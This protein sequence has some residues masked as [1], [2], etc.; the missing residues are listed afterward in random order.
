[1]TAPCVDQ[2]RAKAECCRD[3]VIKRKWFRTTN[4]V[5]YQHYSA[6]LKPNRAC[7]QAMRFDVVRVPVDKASTEDLTIGG[8]PAASAT[9]HGDQWQ[10][11]VYALR[12]GSDV[13][14]FIFA[15]KQK[16]TESDRNARDTVHSFRRLTRQEIQAARPL[17]ITVITVQPGAT[18]ESL[19]QR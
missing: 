3:N 9:A 6:T 14:R 1:M 5:V 11:K 18:V 4:S 10:F 8:F 12:F 17:R 16:N 15:A 19:S 2:S 7:T 13:Y